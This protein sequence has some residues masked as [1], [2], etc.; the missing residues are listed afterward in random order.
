MNRVLFFKKIA[1][2]W[3]KLG[4]GRTQKMIYVYEEMMSKI[5]SGIRE[6]FVEINGQKLFLDKEDSLMLSIKHHEHEQFEN[7]ILLIQL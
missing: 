2:Y 5:G 1:G 7:K 6:E 4:L 3:V